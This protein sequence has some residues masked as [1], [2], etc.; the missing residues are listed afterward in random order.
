V[1]VFVQLKTSSYTAEQVTSAFPTH[2]G[3]VLQDTDSEDM[4]GSYSA[5]WYDVKIIDSHGCLSGFFVSVDTANLMSEGQLQAPG[6]LV[7]DAW[8][9]AMGT[10]C[11]AMPD[12]GSAAEAGH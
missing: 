1:L 3:P 5:D 10:E 7:K 4:W 9:A 11:H 8:R 6:M 2:T 12:A